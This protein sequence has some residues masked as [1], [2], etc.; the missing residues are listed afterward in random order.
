MKVNILLVVFFYLLVI[1]SCTSQRTLMNHKSIETKNSLDSQLQNLTDQIVI[2]LSQTQ[3]S[4][5]AV[6][7]FSTLRGTATKFGRYLAEELITRLYLTNK[8]SVIERQLLNKVLQEHQLNLSGLIDASSAQELGRILGVDAIASG[9]VTDLG[10]SVKV[11]ARLISTQTGKI[12]SVASVNIIKDDVVGK[13]MGESDMVAKNIDEPNQVG[14]FT[15]SDAP[16]N[17]IIEQNEFTFELKRCRMENRN[18]FCSL[19]IKNNSEN[20]IKLRT[21]IRNTKLFDESG[22]E[23]ALGV[24]KIANSSSKRGWLHMDKLIVTGVPTPAELIF[25]NVSSASTKISLLTISI[26]NG[27]G[28][29][30]FRNIPLEQ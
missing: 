26:G 1:S 23:Y 7:E 10:T 21:A 16:L 4:K 2:S 30:K 25:E 8:F 24:L 28:D 29:V 13:L 15:S 18:V 3:K 27:V 19:I 20:D 5:I 6:I 11:N 14:P 17:M 9:S 22:N 12:F